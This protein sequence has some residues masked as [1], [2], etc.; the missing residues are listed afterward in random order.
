MITIYDCVQGTPE[1]DAIRLGRATASRAADIAAKPTTA[2][3]RNYLME[4]ALERVTG[5][6]AGSTYSNSYMERGT[7]IEPEALAWY[8]AETG[9]LLERTGFIA[10]DDR[11]AG[12]SL[13]G[14]VGD[15]EGTV[16]VK[17]RKPALHIRAVVE[18][19]DATTLR[20]V[21]HQQF[22]TGAQWT[23]VV[24]YC[25]EFPMP[26]A[27]SITRVERDE[28]GVDKYRDL[29]TVFL[30][31]VDGATKLIRG[32]VMREQPVEGEEF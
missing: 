10:M 19:P 20:Q 12:C 23:D 6:P 29:L 30:R 24:N 3:R 1:W 2:A 9:S 25:P 27:L 16:E 22:V 18:G 7:A 28:I 26:G 15:L 8:E 13:D 14:H 17:C 31:D 11:M 21:R 32:T 4:L 5:R